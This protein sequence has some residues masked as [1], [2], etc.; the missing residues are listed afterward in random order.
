MVAVTYGE[1]QAWYN[2]GALR[3]RSD[4]LVPVQQMSDGLPDPSHRHVKS[5]IDRFPQL[6]L[7]DEEGVLLVQLE[8]SRYESGLE[9]ETRVFPIDGIQRLIPL[10]ARAQRILKTRMAGIRLE[11]ACLEQAVRDAW[12]EMGVRRA[13]R[14]G[15]ALVDLLF[16]DGLPV[17]GDSLREA[18]ADG[19]R[20][21]EH[22]DDSPENGPTGR[23]AGKTW[24]PDAFTFT[25]ESQYSKGRGDFDYLQDTGVVLKNCAERQSTG[26]SFLDFYRE[27]LK[28]LKGSFSG[29]T[30]AELVVTESLREPFSQ[31]MSGFPAAFP[32]DVSTLAI[33]L[34]WKASFH[35]QREEI[36]VAQLVHDVR[37][38]VSTVGFES[39][40]AAVWL[41]GCFAGHERIAPAVY[42]ASPD[43][44][45]WYSGDDL[46]IV[47]VSRPQEDSAA[48]TPESS[49]PAPEKE[50]EA[51]PSG[52]EEGSASCH[53]DDSTSETGTA[54]HPGTDEGEGKHAE[55]P[56]TAD[57]ADSAKTDPPKESTAEAGSSDQPS[58]AEDSGS[59]SPQQDGEQRRRVYET[60]PAGAEP[61]QQNLVS[62]N[63]SL[64]D[65]QCS[66]EGANKT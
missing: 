30:L 8:P 25:R 64:G 50:P 61:R 2:Y 59:A 40:V 5:L 6:S 20:T 4:R 34:R 22:K 17:I 49:P 1:F 10:T 39:T 46:K 32:A 51:E 24:V 44:Y 42:A 65:N 38:F 55:E 21:I 62:D 60:T 7:E 3:I 58:A 43:K 13:W 33:F 56:E 54:D 18:V 53:D 14:G 23:D 16:D 52:Q 36:D 41:L 28:N 37:A 48:P 57:V 31:T 35:K 45:H 47:K 15:D 11:N 29:Q 63:G 9:P 12:F 27:R 26:V 19:I 66:N